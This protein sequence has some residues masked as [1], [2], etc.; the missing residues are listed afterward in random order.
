MVM[1]SLNY[2]VR[3]KIQKMDDEVIWVL[4][5]DCVRPEN[6]RWKVLQVRCHN[7]VG[8][9]A[10]GGGKHVTIVLVRQFQTRNKVLIS[11]YQRIDGVLVHEIPSGPSCSRSR[12]GRLAN[13]FAI[14][15]SCT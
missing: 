4:S 8:A 1:R 6:L 12:S 15:S 14:H 3:G 9:S 11:S 10:N 7:H 13:R 5:F 2:F